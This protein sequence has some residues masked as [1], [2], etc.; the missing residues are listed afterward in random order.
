MGRLALDSW[1]RSSLWWICA[2]CT[3]CRRAEWRVAAVDRPSVT[4]RYTTSRP[5]RSPVG[6]ATVADV[7]AFRMAVQHLTT[8]LPTDGLPAA[9]GACAIQNSPPGSALLALHARVDRMTR[10]SLEDA[11]AVKKSLVQTWCMRGA[12]FY[13]PT[14]EAAVFTTGVLPPTG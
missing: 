10:E 1:W 8:R 12:P 2:S 6:P 13:L 7:I 5:G 4:I 9:A 11:V 3:G 14:A